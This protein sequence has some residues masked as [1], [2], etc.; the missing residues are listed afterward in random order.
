MNWIRPLRAVLE[1]QLLR[2]G[3]KLLPLLTPAER[4]LAEIANGGRDQAEGWSDTLLVL[5]G[6]VLQ[7]GQPGGW[8]EYEP[9]SKEARAWAAG[10]GEREM[11]RR[12]GIRISG[13]NCRQVSV[14]Q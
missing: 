13:K 6:Y 14:G 12:H 9:P 4:E 10:L 1:A 7:A 5:A 11:L 3:R 2:L 8:P